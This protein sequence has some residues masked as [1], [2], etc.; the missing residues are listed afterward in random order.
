MTPRY[1]ISITTQERSWTAYLASALFGIG[2]LG[3]AS[4]LAV[5]IN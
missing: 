4:A 5:L 1:Q 3:F 2:M